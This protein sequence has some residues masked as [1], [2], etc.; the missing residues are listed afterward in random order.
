MKRKN[1]KKDDERHLSLTK[2]RKKQPSSSSSSSSSSASSSSSTSISS[3][4]PYLEANEELGEAQKK[5]KMLIA[6]ITNIEAFRNTL[7]AQSFGVAARIDQGL[8]WDEALAQAGLC[9]FADPHHVHEYCQSSLVLRSAMALPDQ[10][11]YE[12]TAEDRGWPQRAHHS[13]YRVDQLLGVTTEKYS[14][15]KWFAKQKIKAICV[16]K[17][18]KEPWNS[19]FHPNVPKHGITV[20]ISRRKETVYIAEYS[21]E[22]TFFDLVSKVI[23]KY[24]SHLDQEICPMNS[25]FVPYGRVIV[26]KRQE[27]FKS[28]HF[29]DGSVIDLV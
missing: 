4:N 1:G 29:V 18:E 12:M 11:F 6:H 8:P 9:K 20:A 5:L 23:E 10:R 2:R 3:K 21:P 14:P 15:E 19:V 26:C 25:V 13:A 16:K 7:F 24:P 28:H 22:M 27:T 17:N